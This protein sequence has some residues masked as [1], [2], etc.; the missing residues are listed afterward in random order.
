MSSPRIILFKTLDFFFMFF[1]MLIL[2]GARLLVRLS[3]SS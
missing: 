1:R 3:V 2:T